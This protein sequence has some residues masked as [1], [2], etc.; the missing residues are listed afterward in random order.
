MKPPLVSTSTLV[1]ASTTIVFLLFF[2]GYGCTKIDTPLK[3]DENPDEFI[4]IPQKYEIFDTEPVLIE[5]QGGEGAVL[6]S[7]EPPNE[8]SFSPETGDCVEFTPHGVSEDSVIGIVTTDKNDAAARIDL[9]VL[10]EGT[11]PQRGDIL[12]NEIAWAGTL[13]SWRDE[14]IELINKTERAFYLNNWR[15][16]NAA[17]GKKP[18]I[19]SAKI[20]AGKIF[21]ITNYDPPDEHTAITV[22]SD[23]SDSGLSLSNSCCGPLVLK[24]QKGE[25]IDTVGDGGTYPYGVNSTELKSSM[26]RYS[27]SCTS[28]WDPDSWYTE[29]VSIHLSDD[30]RGTP[31]APNSDQPH[32]SG[33]SEDDALAI[34]TEFS[35][36]VNDGLVED[37]VELFITRSGNLKS[38]VVTDLDGM[39]NDTSITNKNDIYVEKGTSILVIWSTSHVQD[40]NRFFIPDCNPTG[41]KDELVLLCNG[42]FLDGLCYYSTSE[43]QFD[44]KQMIEGYG[45]KGDPIQGKHASKRI[46]ENGNYMNDMQDASWDTNS[47]PTPG[48]MN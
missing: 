48:E 43:A 16:E 10:D 9:L 1:S 29:N 32:A 25:I 33:P 44:D 14:Y 45:W 34:I 46:D 22:E 18:L 21:L 41:T 23:Y 27:H 5:A 47:E 3:E 24:N 36:D 20:Q 17:G 28:S 26:S 31:G 42:F 37:W 13:K 12:I 2:W 4:V 15:I 40:K 30:T 38:F 39:E 11:P 6:W 19:L 35:I 7:T 8:G